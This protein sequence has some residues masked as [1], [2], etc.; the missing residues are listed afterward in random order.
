MIWISGHQGFTSYLCL[1]EY[2]DE[3]T[4]FPWAL[5]VENRELDG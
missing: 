5:E 3:W 1:S 4:R 2:Q